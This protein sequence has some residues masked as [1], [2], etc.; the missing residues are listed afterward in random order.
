MERVTASRLREVMDY[1]PATGAFTWRTKC[2]SKAAGG[3]AGTPHK[4]YVRIQVDGRLY[5][6]HRLAWLYM[7]GEWPIEVDHRNGVGSD[8]RWGNLRPADR[9]TN[10]Q[11]KRRAHRNS[12]TGLL[13]AFPQG[14]RFRA[15]IRIESKCVSLGMFATAEAAHAA[16]VEAKRK[17]HAGCT[18]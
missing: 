18:L 6:A 7:T 16:Y 4:E 14:D 10:M 11:N 13:G 3:I 9:F 17:H 2:G 15:R 1:D 12:K 8:N 5:R